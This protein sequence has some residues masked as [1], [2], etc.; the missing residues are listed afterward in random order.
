M[1]QQLHSWNILTSK[2]LKVVLNL[3]GLTNTHLAS[4]LFDQLLQDLKYN[5]KYHAL[6]GYLK[7]KNSHVYYEIEQSSKLVQ[8]GHCTV[9][10]RLYKFT[11]HLK[12]CAQFNSLFC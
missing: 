6:L 3:Q 9:K 7:E 2:T 5:N 8:S 11:C 1:A 10:K 12:I 4:V